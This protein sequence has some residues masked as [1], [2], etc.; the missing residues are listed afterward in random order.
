[1]RPERSWPALA[2]CDILNNAHIDVLLHQVRSRRERKVNASGIVDWLATEDCG[3]Y[4]KENAY[5]LFWYVL[6]PLV[7][8]A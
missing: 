8:E 7:L 1:M 2:L 3:G 5:L 4:L 6:H